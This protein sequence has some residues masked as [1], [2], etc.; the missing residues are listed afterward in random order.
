MVL[1]TERVLLKAL[2]NSEFF[3]NSTLLK[4]M[5]RLGVKVVPEVPVSAA[6]FLFEPFKGAKTDSDECSD[7][8][9]AFRK[10]VA[11]SQNESLRRE[12]VVDFVATQNRHVFCISVKKLDSPHVSWVFARESQDDGF[13]TLTKTSSDK[14]DGDL[15]H[16]P[17]SY[18]KSG[19]LSLRM[20][21]GD[22][23]KALHKYDQ[24]LSLN[25]H[26]SKYS[27]KESPTETAK[28]IVEGTFGLAVESL[29]QHVSSGK[30]HKQSFI[31]II[32]TTANILTCE[33]DVEDLT[34]DG[35]SNMRTNK[36]GPI[37]YDCPI[38][39][40]AR[41]PNQIIDVEDLEM[42]RRAVRWPVVVMNYESFGNIFEYMCNPEFCSVTV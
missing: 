24:A 40:S 6:P 3:L 27:Y 25:I 7:S 31:P 28:K 21:S 14:R 22:R 30:G 13:S 8:S 41:F 35:F 33:Y 29:I 5:K 1:G 42:T 15:L 23:R 9:M 26:E 16:I 38:P 17:Q 11:H 37:I 12:T 10:A 19:N 4:H 39:M 20:E 36:S 34:A 2:N 18:S 32:V